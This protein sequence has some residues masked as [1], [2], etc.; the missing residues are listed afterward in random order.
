MA[1][2]LNEWDAISPLLLEIA[3][4]GASHDAPTVAA[5]E[6]R[7]QLAGATVLRRDVEYVF[8]LEEGLPAVWERHARVGERLQEA[9]PEYG[10]E[11]FAEDG[12]R[13]PQL[14]AV[15]LPE[16]AVVLYDQRQP[17]ARRLNPT[18]K[19]GNSSCQGRYRALRSRRRCCPPR[20][21]RR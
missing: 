7:Q 15:R 6:V 9:L 14:T 2:V 16:G 3:A 12:H 11:V 4:G 20:A 10:F 5:S 19:R 17:P 1:D 18:H 21:V 8:T 13:L